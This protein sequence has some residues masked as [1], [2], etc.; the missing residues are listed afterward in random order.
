[1]PSNG[2][3]TNPARRAWLRLAA[4]AAAFSAA[5]RIVRAQTQAYP[6]RPVRFVV[7][8]PAGGL[9]DI[10]ARLIG[11]WLTDRLGQ[12]FIVENKPGA[13]SNLGTEFVA[14]AAPD[15]YTLINLSST[16]TINATMYEKLSFDFL[17]DIAPVASL[18]RLNYVMEVNPS[19]PATTVPEFIAYA[20]ANPGKLSYAST[21]IGTPAHVATELF[22]LMTRTDIVH[23]PYRGAAQAL[24]DLIGGRVQVMFDNMAVSL[25]HIRAGRVRALAVASAK[26]V[27]ALPDLPTV[28]ETLP[29]FEASAMNGIGAPRGTPAEVIERLNREINAALTDPAIRTRLTT[30]GLEVLPGS[31]ADLGTLLADETA[32]WGKVVKFAGIKMD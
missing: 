31:A 6:N 16:N 3:K 19:V 4:G 14:R 15:G 11:Q 30:L 17:R 7:P 20:K 13:S 24:P 25:E 23:V 21:G 26:R 27:G 32:K 10:V 28:S 8:Y 18:V 29:G 12:P 9:S 2:D 1:M 22:K 5:P